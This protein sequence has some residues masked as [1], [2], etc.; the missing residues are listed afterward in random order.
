MGKRC[1]YGGSLSCPIFN[2]DAADVGRPVSA[3]A[4]K[5]NVKSVRDE[6]TLARRCDIV[7]CLPKLRSPCYIP[8]GHKF[9]RHLY[10]L[11]LS[12]PRCSFLSLRSLGQHLNLWHRKLIRYLCKWNTLHFLLCDD[13]IS[14]CSDAQVA[15]P[16]LVNLFPPLSLSN[17][18]LALPLLSCSRKMWLRLPIQS[19]LR[20]S[21]G[22]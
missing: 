12:R 21:W 20:L 17:V 11:H 9:L 15:L 1:I 4:A 8:R 19:A 16:K 6:G 2:I 7:T 22:P 18:C 3:T 13:L 5:E 10:A 14:C